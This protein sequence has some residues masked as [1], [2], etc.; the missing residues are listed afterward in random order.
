[1]AQD[2][3]AKNISIVVPFATGGTT[4]AIARTL[5]QELSKAWA[6]P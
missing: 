4:D 5:G 2:W 1:M 3:P 6:N